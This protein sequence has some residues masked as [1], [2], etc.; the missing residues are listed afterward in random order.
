MIKGMGKRIVRARK[1]AGKTRSELAAAIGVD[2]RKL[3]KYETDS[4]F[5]PDKDLVKMSDFL[6]VRVEFFFREENINFGKIV[7]NKISKISNRDL[8]QVLEKITEKAERIFEAAGILEISP[9]PKLSLPMNFPSKITSLDDVKSAASIIKNAWGI[10]PELETIKALEAHGILV[11][12]LDGIT[13]KICGLSTTING[14]PV[15]AIQGRTFRQQKQAIAHELGHI[16]LK[17]KIKG[18]NEEVACNAFSAELTPREFEEWEE[19]HDLERSHLL[20]ELTMRAFEEDLI[21]HSVAARLLGITPS[22]FQEILEQ[23]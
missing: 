16:V 9:V 23:E 11:F 21:P 12:C 19:E 8:D 15:I 7:F 10:S 2:E 1:A 22:D 5:V 18:L 6:N 3:M 17:G 13:A 20:E 14:F 4:V